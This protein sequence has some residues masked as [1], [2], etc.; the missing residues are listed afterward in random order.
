MLDLG[1]ERKIMAKDKKIEVQKCSNGHIMQF[2][3]NE[4]G[5]TVTKCV[6]CGHEEKFIA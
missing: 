3:R 1:L 5:F 4:D 6:V 2:D